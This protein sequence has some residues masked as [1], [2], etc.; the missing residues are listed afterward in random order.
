MFAE[1]SFR[2]S[3][4]VCFMQYGVI[5]YMFWLCC[6][7]LAIQEV[8]PKTANSALKRGGGCKS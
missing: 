8:G 3:L 5:S 1:L 6:M 4:T 7:M 2:G